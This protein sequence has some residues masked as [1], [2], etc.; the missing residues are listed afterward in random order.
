MGGGGGG[1]KVIKLLNNDYEI[2]KLIADNDLLR[3]IVIS[4]YVKG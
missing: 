2:I 1:E 4:I 3:V